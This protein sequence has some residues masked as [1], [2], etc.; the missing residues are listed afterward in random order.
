M[1][2]G[3]A[4]ISV[5]RQALEEGREAVALGGESFPVNLTRAKKLR[6]V[7]T[8]ALEIQRHEAEVVRK[9]RRGRPLAELMKLFDRLVELRKRG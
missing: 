9:L 4:L 8:R 2:L 1:T 3:D 6:T 7:A 5:W